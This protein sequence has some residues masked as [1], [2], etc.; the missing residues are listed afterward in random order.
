MTFPSKKKMFEIIKLSILETLKQKTKSFKRQ[1]IP[2]T[3]SQNQKFEKITSFFLDIFICNL[4]AELNA[5]SNDNFYKRLVI[6]SM[7]SGVKTYNQSPLE[8]E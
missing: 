7:I 5:S 2:L 8:Q 4:Y 3:L 1:G 6:K